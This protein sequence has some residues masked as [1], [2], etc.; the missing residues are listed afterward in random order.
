MERLEFLLSE[1]FVPV[2]PAFPA[3]RASFRPLF[4]HFR[5]ALQFSRASRP[6]LSLFSDCFVGRLSFVTYLPNDVY[7]FL[8]ITLSKL[9]I[10]DSSTLRVSPLCAKMLQILSFV[11]FC[12]LVSLLNSLD[13]RL[14]RDKERESVS[15]VV[16]KSQ[17][18]IAIPATKD[19]EKHDLKTERKLTRV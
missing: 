8:R 9:L 12:F 13:F 2:L 5:L 6:F 3:P 18:T 1:E 15:L 11:T 14:F 16:G 19:L 7:C 17:F 4:S 10:E